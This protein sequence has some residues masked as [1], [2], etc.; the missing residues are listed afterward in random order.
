MDAADFFEQLW[1]Q[2]V[3]MAPQV[4]E[5][6]N[7]VQKTYGSTVNDHV[8]FRTFDQPGYTIAEL[9]PAFLA[10]GYQRAERYDFLDKHLEAYAYE[11]PEDDLPLVF[12][13]QLRTGALSGPAQRAIRQLLSSASAAHSTP[14][15]R[16]LQG[17]TW[18]MPSATQYELLEAESAYA[19]WLSVWGLCANHFTIAIHKLEP[20]VSLQQVVESVQQAGY[21]MNVSGG[22]IKGSP[23]QLLE[24][25][26]T[27]AELRPV[28]LSDSSREICSCYYEFAQRHRLSDG[29]LYKGFVAASA[30]HIFEST[31]SSSGGEGPAR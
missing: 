8:A 24:Q 13:S 26:S 21:P 14:A 22:L 20:N 18:P 25:A 1:A 29:Q 7:H 10:F 28:A 17:R 2:Y 9:E 4:R 31:T 16:L 15:E 23:E 5:I 19:A 30:S 12:F 6:R 27:V 3:A 11:P